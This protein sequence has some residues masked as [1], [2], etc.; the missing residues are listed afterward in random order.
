MEEHSHNEQNVKITEEA[1]AE[2]RKRLGVVNSPRTRPWNTELTRDNIYHFAVGYGDDNPLWTDEQ[3]AQKT[4]WGGLLAPPT[5]LMTMVHGPGMSG[6][7]GVHALHAGVDFEWHQ[8]LRLGEPI[9]MRIYMSKLEEKPSR[10]A[11]RTFL[12]V[13]TTEFLD[14]KGEL[15]AVLRNSAIRSE[16]EAAREKGKYVDIT[17]RHWTDEAIRKLDTEYEAERR[18]GA[19]PRYWEDVQVGE[20]L[21]HVVKGPLTV[22][23]MIAFKMG[24]HLA[25]TR[26]HRLEWEFRQRHPAAG[27]IKDQ[28]GIPDVP[29]RV[30]WDDEFARYIG[31]PGAYDYGPQRIAWLGHL[32]TNWAGDDGFPR[33]LNVQIRRFNLIGDL[34]WARGR[35]AGKRTDPE[36]HT[37]VD[38]DI[39]TENQRGDKTAF[40][41]AVVELPR[42][43]T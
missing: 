25:F 9:T 18:R 7:P 17:H 43:A 2:L 31:A 26:A 32:L 40:G 11:G 6:L 24:G 1:L 29:E 21:G 37:L 35:V 23:D 36:G 5:F 16:R 20:S 38:C 13:S 14:H 39:W 4:R 34:T 27:M 22:R 3:Y 12:Q 10:F 15:L 28:Y 19:T 8:P 33:R 42:K 41:Q 30:H